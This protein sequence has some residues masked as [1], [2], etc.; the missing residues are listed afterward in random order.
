MTDTEVIAYLFDL[1]VR[2]HKLPLE[3]AAAALAPP[4]WKDID[5]MPEQQRKPTRPS[6]RSTAAR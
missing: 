6:G 4:F 3:I 2:R 5:A 1:L